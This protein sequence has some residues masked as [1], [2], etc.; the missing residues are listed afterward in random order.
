MKKSSGFTVIEL[1][2]VI[3]VMAV[4]VWLFFSEK[5]TVEAVQRDSQRKTAINAIYYSLEEVFY[6]K[7]HYYPQA[8]DSKTLRAVD[9][10]L[11][12][13]PYGTALGTS[14]SDYRYETTGCTTD[15]HCTGYT[16]QSNM[17]RESAYVKTNR[18]H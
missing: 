9:P 11:F 2:I 6:D 13:D 4:G 8:I 15:G 10:V 12:N 18:S 14:D 7:N 16:L 3:V 1:L 17:E 5:T